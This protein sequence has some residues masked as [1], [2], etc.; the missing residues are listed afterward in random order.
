MSAVQWDRWTERGRRKQRGRERRE[1]EKER[2][3]VRDW[4]VN[5]GTAPPQANS[6]N[7]THTRNSIW[8]R[9]KERGR[10]GQ[11]LGTNKSRTKRARA[12]PMKSLAPL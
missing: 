1:R 6:P 3:T 8:S 10:Q 5:P 4:Q 2:E 11:R 7:E 12:P 9:Q